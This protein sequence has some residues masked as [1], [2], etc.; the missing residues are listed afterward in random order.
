MR[1]VWKRHTVLQCKEP[2]PESF[3]KTLE[4]NGVGEWHCEKRSSVEDIF[5]KNRK[6][7]LTISLRLELLQD[8]TSWTQMTRRRTTHSRNWSMIWRQLGLS[9]K[10]F[11]GLITK[12]KFDLSVINLR[13]CLTAILQ[14]ESI[15]SSTVKQNKKPNEI[16]TQIT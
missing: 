11:S 1:P 13:R 9:H 2:R 8:V 10:G 7:T 6:T 12:W 3:P 15:D 14:I 5:R 4:K 16:Y